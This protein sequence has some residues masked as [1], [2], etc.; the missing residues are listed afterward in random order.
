M[1]CSK[2][3]NILEDGAKFCS[4][5]GA[6]VESTT[7][8]NA[9]CHNHEKEQKHLDPV[10]AVKLSMSR[11]LDF[12]GRS[13]RSEYWWT[14]AAV[15][16]AEGMLTSI[17]PESMAGPVSA[18]CFLALLAVA[19]RRLHDVGKSGW[20]YL[21][22]FLP[23]FGWIVLLVQNVKDSCPGENQYGPNPKDM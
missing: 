1:F 7:K 11:L 21:F 10:S 19:V 3:G 15:G 4:S 13:R 23:V 5:C 18:L 16:I 14:A 17:L 2:C 22:H 20:W 6:K 8:V 12:S 9:D